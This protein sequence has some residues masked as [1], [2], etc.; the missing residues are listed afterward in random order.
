M[1]IELVESHEEAASRAGVLGLVAGPGLAWQ[2]GADGY[3]ASLGAGFERALERVGFK[4]DAGQSYSFDTGSESPHTVVAL[5][6]G[7]DPGSD[8]LRRAAGILGR[9]ASKEASVAM[10]LA[11]EGQAAPLVEGFLL[12]QYSYDRFRSKPEPARTDSLLLVGAG[13]RSDCEAGAVV[14]DAVSWARDLVNTPARDKAPLEIQRR[15]AEM[16]ER[17]GLRLETHDVPDLEEGGFGGLLG[18]AAG[19]D[20]DPCLVELWYEPEGA[21]TFVA[22]VGK[23]ITFDSGGLSIKPAQAM[24]TM[25]TDMSGAAAVVGAMQAIARLRLPVKVL[26][27]APLTDN[28]PGSRATKPGD[29]LTTRNGK[30]IEVLNTDAEGRLIL[31]DALAY[32]VEHGPDLMVD[33]ATLTGACKVALGDTIAGVMGNDDSLID[34]IEKAGEQAG[35]RVWRLPLPEEYRR[36]LDTPMADMKNIGGRWGGA[37]TAALLLQEFVG[38]VPWA[39]LDIAGPA[40]WTR[41]EHY[42]SKGGSGFGVRTLV[43]LVA[44]LAEQGSGTTE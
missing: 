1:D 5:G 41:N 18:V 35:E 19:S 24:A 7:E 32:A 38:D 33:L 37:L 21:E 3:V 13:E 11:V 16:A 14:A 36:Q 34:R 25:K 28:M 23:G 15:V 20:R 39:H 31:A 44:D 6:V 17:S 43:E 27:L 12:S 22:L 9:K 2:G 4:G 42:Q 8:T 29:V 40:R 10:T 30:T 26:G